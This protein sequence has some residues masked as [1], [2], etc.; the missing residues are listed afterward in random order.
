MKKLFRNCLVALSALLV[1][2]ALGGCSGSMTNLTS[3]QDAQK[4]PLQLAEEYVKSIDSHSADISKK[5]DE[6]IEAV[7]K[8]DSV[9]AKLKLEE[10]TKALDD[11]ANLTVPETLKDEGGKYSQAA[12]DLKDALVALNDV[13]AGKV[14]ADDAASRVEQLQQSYEGA[15]KNLEEADKSL[16]EK[17]KSLSDKPTA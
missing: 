3:T 7:G 16:Q 15:A 2:V 12:K 4:T 6:Y 13:V 11:A 17:V 10:I 8:S 1:V 5:A 9:A 14:S